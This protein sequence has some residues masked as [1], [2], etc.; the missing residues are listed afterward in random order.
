MHETRRFC[1]L[2]TGRTGSNALF[3]G[4][5]SYSDIAIPTLDGT[6]GNSELLNPRVVD[7]YRQLLARHGG[8]AATDAESTVERF[9]DSCHG[10]AFA[11]FKLMPW[12][13]PDFASFIQRSDVQRI[14][15][16]RDDL[17]S[18]LA[19]WFIANRY[20]SWQKSSRT[21]VAQ[22][23]FGQAHV[24]ELRRHLVFVLHAT[25]QL[26]QV[27]DAIQ[28]RYEDLC[29]PTFRSDALDTFFG[30]HIALPKP[31]PATQAREYLRNWPDFVAFVNAEVARIRPRI[32]AGEFDHVPQLARADAARGLRPE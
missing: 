30:R 22:W 12:Q 27:R 20:D 4:I 7:R 31:N 23:T 8:P 6:A 13:H 17:P 14:V 10:S 16:R 18:M 26:E 28:L 32:M 5:A 19:S 21:V 1:V 2:T 11:G 24:A 29:Q 9:F 15:L 25:Y 3:D